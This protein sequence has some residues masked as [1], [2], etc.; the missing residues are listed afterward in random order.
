MVTT[1]RA[2]YGRLRS[3]FGLGFRATGLPETEPQTRFLLGDV[4][5]SYHNKEAIGV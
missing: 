2:E 5:L 3:R 1:I 4:D